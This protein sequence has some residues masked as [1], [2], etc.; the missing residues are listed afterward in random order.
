MGKLN[1]VEHKRVKTRRT[2]PKFFECTQF[3][4]GMPFIMLL[5]TAALLYIPGLDSLKP[6][7]EEFNVRRTTQIV[8]DWQRNFLNTLTIRRGPCQEGEHPLFY[9]QWKG[10]EKGCKIQDKTKLITFDQWQDECFG[11]SDDCG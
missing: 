4:I 9:R 1:L 10:L 7:L 8:D 11:K 5:L 3:S 2:T 6:N